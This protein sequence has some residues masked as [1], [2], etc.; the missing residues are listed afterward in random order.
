MV[1]KKGKQTAPLLLSASLLAVLLLFWVYYDIWVEWAVGASPDRISAIARVDM[2]LVAASWIAG[3][4]FT[5]LMIRRFIWQGIV[6]QMSGRPVPRL[7]T[8]LFNGLITA[9]VVIG[10]LLNALSVSWM[11]VTLVFGALF[12]LVTIF[13]RKPLDDMFAGLSLQMDTAIGIG[14]VIRMPGGETGVIEDTSWRSTRLRAHDGRIIM[15]PNGQIASAV[16]TRLSGDNGLVSED[17]RLTLDFTVAVDRAVRVL[18]AAA[19]SAAGEAGIT[20]IPSPEAE[21]I[22][23]GTSGIVYR[24]RYYK[25]PS[26]TDARMARTTVM[27]QVMVH[28]FNAGLAIAQPKQN[29]FLGRARFRQLDWMAPEDRSQLIV[30]IPIFSPLHEEEAAHVADSLI[31]HRYEPGDVIIEQGSAGQSMFGLTEGLLEVLVE[32][33]EKDE[34][35][36]VAQL[37]PGAF[38]GEMSL[39]VGEPRSAT[40]RA[41]TESVAYE[42]RRDT[43]I[44]LLEARPEIGEALSEVI[45]RRNIDRTLKIEDTTRAEREAAIAASSRTMFARMKSIFGSVLG[46][47]EN[48]ARSA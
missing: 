25:E 3:G 5:A 18:T 42:I 7:L 37:D 47:G 31:M 9:V 27:R 26:A 48:R 30:S 40:V 2:I 45:A 11:T 43:I 14:D 20:A 36:N 17:I 39:L 34:L 41:V 1:P 15:V 4:V 13:L 32:H 10:I 8:G 6:E 35:I 19:R 38:F 28:L 16:I 23:T 46:R 33:P 22:E 29:V 44:E 21:V 12:L 24:L